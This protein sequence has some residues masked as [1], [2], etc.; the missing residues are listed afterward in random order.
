MAEA[1][2]SLE[3]VIK[4]TREI[5]Q[6]QDLDVLLERI[7]TEAR[8]IANADAGSIYIIEGTSLK[9]S[10][11]QNNTLQKKLPIGKKLIYNTYTIPINNNSIAGYVANTGGIVNIEDAYNIDP[12]QPY[13]FEKQFDVLS[14]YR[15]ISM[16][17]I[18]I[19]THYGSIVG[20]IQLI[21]AKYPDGAIRVFS[22]AEEP[23]IQH[24]ADNAA[25]A[26]ERAKMTRSML[27]RMVKMAELRDP[28]ETF[29]HVNRVAAYSVEIYEAWAHK[30]GIPERDIQHN[31]DILHMAAILHDVGKIAIS[32]NILKKA[33]DLSPEERE[34]VK[35][36]TVQGAKLFADTFSDFDE[37]AA[38][39]ALN[40]HERWDGDG[41]PG[42]VNLK[43]GAPL[44]GYDN[45]KGIAVG[46]RGEE[47]PIFGRIVAIADVYDALSCKRA[48]K[49]AWDEPKVLELIQSESGKRFDPDVVAAFFSCIDTLRSIQSRYPE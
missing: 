2:G 42:H 40:H 38:E 1:N 32:D 14:G 33:S 31:R 30:K 49:D 23:I 41:Y 22:E 25:I 37:A 20:V 8:K 29:G 18:P 39:V 12:T 21:N 4:T 24:F 5:L 34:L 17:T 16:L 15:T 44:P 46:K 3:N 7:L 6:I 10:Y 36:H 47:I 27:S 35:Q 43:D 11:T 9:F 19:K 48:Y 26:I 13:Q 45:G 28:T